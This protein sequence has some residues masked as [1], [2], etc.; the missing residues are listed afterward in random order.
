MTVGATGNSDISHNAATA[1]TFTASTWNTS[2]RVTVSAAQDDGYDDES[3]TI[4]HTVTSTDTDYHN[5]AASAVTVNVTDDEDVPVEVS[6]GQA[7]H[8]DTEGASFEITVS[9]DQD[10]DRT[11]RIPIAKTEN[12]ASSADYEGVPSVVTFMPVGQ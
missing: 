10:P 9:L 12:G 2:Q 5:I 6:F 7:V 1:L 11:V 3:A 8:T 4:S